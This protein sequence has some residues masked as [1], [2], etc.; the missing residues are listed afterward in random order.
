MSPAASG[1]TGSVLES[2]WSL[3]VEKCESPVVSGSVDRDREPAPRSR[4]TRAV[5]RGDVASALLAAAVVAAA[6]LVPHLHDGTVT[7]LL[8]PSRWGYFDFADA[9]PLSGRRLA[10]IGWGTPAAVAIAAAVVGWGPA[11]AQRLSWRPLLALTWL[12][13]FGWATAL[14]LIDGFN[15]GFASKFTGRD[16]YRYEIARFADIGAALHVFTS[17]IRDGAPDS[18]NTQVSG[19]PPGAILVFVGLDRIGLGGAT[20]AGVVVT[21]VGAS[22]AAAI[23]VTLR[24]LGEEAVARRAA[25]FL[26]VAPA[27][28]WIAVSADAFFAGVV[29][30][31]L[32]LLAWAAT[33]STRCP[34]AA[35]ITAGVLLGLG[36]YLSYGL[37]LMAVPAVAILLAARTPRPLIGALLGALAVAAAFAAAGFWWF[38]GYAE[39]RVR[40]YQGVGAARPYLYW[41]WANCASLL[42]AVGLA[43]AA[44]LPRALSWPKLRASTPLHVLVAAFLV[45]VTL[46][47]L[48]GLSKAE[49]ERIWLP[50]AL[51]ILAAAALLPPA[52]HRFWLALQAGGA[53]AINHLILTNW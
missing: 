22:A 51:W 35:A 43:S 1:R 20:G 42:C 15:Q 41:V 11:V 49:T 3:I 27:A 50:F 32:A 38:D 34:T 6:F 31:G 16:D 14:A 23:L 18:W 39:V 33:R 21:A 26:A 25:P 19:H 5:T 2:W 30:W 4:A 7:P 10:H 46:A 9:A 52:S 48:S 24:A 44:A 45:A 29:A 8:S 12:T 47:D 13:G 37:V 40:Y 36:I 17:R 53:L 28:I